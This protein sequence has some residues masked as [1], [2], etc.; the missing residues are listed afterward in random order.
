MKIRKPA[1][2]PILKAKKGEFD[3]LVNLSGSASDKVIPL[4]D[5]PR[6]S[7]P[8]RTI[9]EFLQKTANNIGKVRAGNTIFLDMFYWDARMQM[10]TGEHVLSYM[11]TKLKSLGVFV[12]P[13]IGYDRWDEPQYQYALQTIE[14]RTDQSFCIRLDTD[15]I[16]D[17]ADT[18][19]FE[20]RLDEM[21]KILDL[22][23]EQCSVML[24]FGDISKYAL[25][26]IIDTAKNAVAWLSSKNFR[27][28][29]ITGCSLPP[30]ISDAVHAQDT[31]SL[32]LRKEMLVWKSVTSE[33][34]TTP[35]VFGDYCIRNPL[36]QENIIAKHQ[37]GKIRYTINN[38]YFVVRGRSKQLTPLTEQNYELANILVQSRHYLGASFSW[39]DQRIFDCSQKNFK[40]NS[41]NWV[42]I[43]TNH[44]IET[45]LAEIFEYQRQA[46]LVKSEAYSG[47]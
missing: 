14:R 15:A 36:S 18:D 26:D 45:V 4:I 31:S 5:I 40:G 38:H 13:V 47:N 8:E 32:V 29:I 43:D 37:N 17:I 24:D 7:D 10:E 1:Y 41:T 22:R 2:V 42:S 19:F 6:P 30:S 11:C 39:G 16:A 20:E 25:L 12:N 23:Y 9:G 3:A 21:V 34:P 28:V 35:I 46:S 33:M 27:Y 44:H